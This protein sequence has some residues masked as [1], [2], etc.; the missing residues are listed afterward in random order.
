MKSCKK[1]EGKNRCSPYDGEMMKEC[2][3]SK[4]NR[5][6]YNKNAKRITNNDSAVKK[7]ITF[8]SK[9]ANHKL[10]LLSNFSE[11]EIV[12][13]GKTFPTGE[14]A[15]HSFKY[16]LAAKKASPERKQ[17]VEEY[18]KKFETNGTIKPD[19][20]SAKIAGGKGKKGF[21]LNE[22]E[23]KDWAKNSIKIQTLICIYKIETY[24]D[25]ID[26]LMETGDYELIHQ[27]NRANNKEIWGARIDK[28]TN[29]LVGKNILGKIWMKFRKKI[30]KK[31]NK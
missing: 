29:K 4:K 12:I 11:L 15:F 14:H 23:L 21:R 22:N 16:R 13:N 27:V 25:I 24:P 3:I 8:Y 2:D 17:E 19:G 20:L 10:R 28:N 26:I 31:L 6:I 18:A 30:K 1:I 7:R 9:S 5:C